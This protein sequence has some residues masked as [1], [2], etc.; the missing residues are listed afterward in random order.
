[1]DAPEQSAPAV[2]FALRFPAYDQAEL[3]IT[4]GR[5]HS[6]KVYRLTFDQIRLLVADGADF[7]AKYPI[8][9]TA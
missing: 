7:I 2:L 1:M 4:E 6:C 8:E 9:P 5:K 3:V